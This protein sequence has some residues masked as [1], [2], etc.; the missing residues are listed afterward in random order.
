MPTGLIDQQHGLRIGRHGLGYLFQMKRHG[1]RGASGQDQSRALAGGGADC[2]EDIGRPGPLIAQ[3]HRPRSAF[4]P[5]PRDL[6]L[7]ANPGFVL[8]PYLYALALRRGGN[9]R[10]AGWEVFLNSSSTSGF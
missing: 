1:G 8:P 3:R 2:P 10:Q 9:F 4:R 5:S 6:V 7:L